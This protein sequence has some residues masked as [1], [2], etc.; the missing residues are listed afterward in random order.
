MLR[1]YRISM[2]KSLREQ[3]LIKRKELSK[4]EVEKKSLQIQHRLFSLPWYHTA[5][6]ILFYV[7]YD[8]EVDTHVMIKESLMNGKTVLVPKT[9]KEKKTICVSRLLCWEDL[10]PCAYSILEPRENCIREV[11]V[12]SVE[13]LIV[14]G[15]VFDVCGNRIGHGMGYYDRLLKNTIQAHSIGLAFE[16]QII[17]AIPAEKHD[18]KVEM[19]VTEK[20]SI[21]CQ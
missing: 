9:D 21:H 19:I 1:K 3:F 14:P 13:L 11:P 6:N 5:Q 16:S 10:S 20:R 8:N 15:I 7:S 4:S 2:K 12:T 18:E 17:K